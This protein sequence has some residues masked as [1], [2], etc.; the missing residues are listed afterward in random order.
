MSATPPVR[1]RIAPSPTGF[2]HVGNARTAIFNWLFARAHGGAFVW[3]VEDTDR[4]RFV[5]EALD[6]QRAALDWL[7]I[8]PDEGPFTGGAFGPYMQ[9]ERIDRY[10][11]RVDALIA[12]GKAY[13]CF[14]TPERLD[15]VRRARELGKLK[16]RYDRH[17]RNLSADEVA[18][19][20]AE[21]GRHTVRLAMPLAGTRTLDDV[22][23]GEIAFDLAELDDPIILKSDGWPTYHLA[24]VVDDEAMA[25]THVLRAD[26]WI[27]SAPIHL[28][29]Y[30]SFGWTP[31][32][33]CHVPLVLAP[34][35]KGKLS[36]RHG[37]AEVRDYRAAGYLPEA[38]FN[39]LALL[40]W[41]FSG[42][43]EIFTPEQAAARF[44]LGDIKVSPAAWNPDK[45]LWMNGHYIR[46]LAPDDLAARLVPF[47]ADAGIEA[48]AA[49]VLALVPLIQ[50]RITTLLE[51]VPL[52]DFFWATRITPEVVDLVPNKLAPA[53]VAANLR[54]TAE[55]LATV[56]HWTAEELEEELRAL[57]EALGVKAG[58]LFQPVRVAVT[59]KKIAP[60]LFETLA[61]VGKDKVIERLTAAATLLEGG[62][63]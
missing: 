51:V 18:A 21:G 50:E 45:L 13:R 29:L 26:E 22:L 35:G 52:V 60:P 42:D 25:I 38:L 1:V 33:Y 47:L 12:G 17:C 19:K 49:E 59:G 2:F 10:R 55:A 58:P 63:G 57:S 48:T 37:G 61:L 6:D 11:E 53:D 3:R 27:P 40:G 4:S 7:G 41:A 30:E 34:D 43:E 36:K 46:S 24:V 14:C 54:R 31:P 44:E 9:S 20:R 15:E 32:V 8:T 56:V 5:A 39:Y 62:A 23:R 16:G 28:M